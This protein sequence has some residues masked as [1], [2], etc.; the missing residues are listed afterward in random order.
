[1]SVRFFFLVLLCSLLIFSQIV[2]SDDCNLLEWKQEGEWKLS[3]D[4]NRSSCN[5]N[6]FQSHEDECW[7]FFPHSC[8][9][10][11]IATSQFL[12][13]AMKNN[14]HDIVF[15]GT[16]RTR[17]LFYDTCLIL[18]KPLNQL[19]AV[20]AHH[21]LEC[22]KPG[23]HDINLH[24]HWLDCG[25]DIGGDSKIHSYDNTLENMNSFLTKTNLFHDCSSSSSS[26]I[27]ESIDLTLKKN[28][29]A[30]IFTTGV[31]EIERGVSVKNFKTQVPSFVENVLHKTCFNCNNKNNNL[32]LLKTEEPVKITHRFFPFLLETNEIMKDVATNLTAKFQCDTEVP[33]PIL[34]SFT[35]SQDWNHGD[36]VHLYKANRHFIGNAASQLISRKI[37]TLLYKNLLL[38]E[39]P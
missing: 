24:Y 18:G 31:C 36:E 26:S 32:H 28:R 7:E 3:K 29:T 19:N 15:I 33:I 1:M 30:I 39:S 11:L 37:L 4:F 27:E 21:N 16:S 34:D 17:T 2:K 8:D 20:M 25:L 35:A 22:L 9:L 6:V 23:G 38:G 12:D 13:T 10:S 5:D 14:L